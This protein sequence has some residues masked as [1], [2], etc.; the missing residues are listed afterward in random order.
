M[1]YELLLK[2][3][4]AMRKEI[5][6]ALYI[7]TWIALQQCAIEF[8]PFI[9]GNQHQMEQSEVVCAIKTRV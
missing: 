7:L 6:R 8:N 9:S 3:V 4:P 2:A 1:P 5:Q